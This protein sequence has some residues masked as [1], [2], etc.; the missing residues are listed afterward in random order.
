M[1]KLFGRKDQAA[2]GNSAE[3]SAEPATS[4]TPKDLLGSYPAKNDDIKNERL[5]IYRN[6]RVEHII[7]GSLLVVCLIQAS[8][9]MNLLPLYRV[10]PFFVTFSDKAEQVV[11]IQPP[12]GRHSSI[13]I[14]TEANVRDYV[15]LRN[16]ISQD[17]AINLARWGGKV[18]MMSSQPIYE[19][20]LADIKPVYELAKAGKFTRSVTIDS[21]IRAPEGYYRVDFTAYDRTIGAGLTDTAEATS[22]WTVE[23]RAVNRPA[24]VVYANRFQNPLG[25]EVI[26]YTATPRRV[27]RPG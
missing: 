17:D 27:S 14:L 26:S 3:I 7:I 21:I 9:I 5:R 10:V 23:L 25:F 6:V 19:A 24:N 11:S 1:R 22:S 12:S 13:E 8:V 16:T 18:E 2:V 4:A 15:R 20:F